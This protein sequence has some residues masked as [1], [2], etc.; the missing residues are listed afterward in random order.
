MY[1]LM[2]CMSPLVIYIPSEGPSSQEKKD[3]SLCVEEKLQEQEKEQDFLSIEQKAQELGKDDLSIEQKAQEGKDDSHL[4]EGQEPL[5]WKE[6]EEPPLKRTCS[7]SPLPLLPPFPGPMPP[8]RSFS[9]GQ[10]GFSSP[11]GLPYAMHSHSYPGTDEDSVSERSSYSYYPDP[12][13][14][15]HMIHVYVLYSPL[16]GGCYVYSGTI[17]LY[18]VSGVPISGVYN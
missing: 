12:G 5:P 2:Q 18:Q 13:F 8:T 10:G 3:D 4:D 16:L 14:M 9:Y 11:P 1:T 15:V 6:L 7:R 17:A